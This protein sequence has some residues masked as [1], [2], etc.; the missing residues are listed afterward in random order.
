MF[1]CKPHIYI[2]DISQKQDEVILTMLERAA[3]DPSGIPALLQRHQPYVKFTAD[4]KRPAFHYYYTKNS[5]IRPKDVPD[6]I[7]EFVGELQA[8]VQLPNQIGS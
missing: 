8:L 7:M 4:A 5:R 1:C 2:V 3:I 6:T